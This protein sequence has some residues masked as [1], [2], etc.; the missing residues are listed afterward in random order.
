MNIR[1]ITPSFKGNIRFTSENRRY[2]ESKTQTIEIPAEKI[3][4]YREINETKEYPGGRRP[5]T[6]ITTQITDTAGQ[7]Y[8]F[9]LPLEAVKKCVEQAKKSPK[10]T[11]EIS[12]YIGMA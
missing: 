2:S 3:V 12:D 1:A 6:E 9:R 7:R 4:S 10:E 5:H 8:N 11:V